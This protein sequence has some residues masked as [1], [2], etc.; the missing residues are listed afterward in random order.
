MLIQ[1]DT[2]A[3]SFAK[4]FAGK[5]KK[6]RQAARRALADC[7]LKVRESQKKEIPRGFKV[8]KNNFLES[9]V[10]VL[11]WPK[12]DKLVAHIGID[13]RVQGT[14]LF[15][16]AY[17]EGGKRPVGEGKKK[18]AV[19]ITGSKARQ[20]FSKNVPIKFQ[21]KNL[22]IDKRGRGLHRTVLLPT[23]KGQWTVFQRVKGRTWDKPSKKWKGRR[24]K[25]NPLYTFW[26]AKPLKR[27][28]RFKEK[29]GELATY[30]LP[31]LFNR[32]LRLYLKKG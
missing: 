22:E 30:V 28:M 26:G 8:R 14:P 32:Y 7:A 9:R 15:L 20:T 16:H 13:E 27:R 19:P 17:E 2:N 31:M 21:I 25:L 18:V 1:L 3:S 5:G 23:K 12:N 29:S 6:I 10:K 24:S 11:E 4:E